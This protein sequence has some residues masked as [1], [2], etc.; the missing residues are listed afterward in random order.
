M[1]SVSYYVLGALLNVKYEQAR[2]CF[3][4]IVMCEVVTVCRNRLL[5]YTF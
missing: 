3:R 1:H 4:D 2:E 5:L